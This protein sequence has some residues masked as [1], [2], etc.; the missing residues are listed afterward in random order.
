MKHRIRAAGIALQDNKILMLRVRDQYS[1][2]YWIPPGGGLEDSDVS[3]KQA[4]VRECREE[5]G[6]DVTVGPLLCVREFHEISTDRYHVELFYLLESW[7]GTLSLDNL[8]GLNDS[9]Y[10]QQVAWV[11]I[12]ALNQYK[13]FPADI[14][15]TIL[16]L[17]KTEQFATHLGSY[18]QGSNDDVNYLD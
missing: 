14:A 2:E 11:D 15:S 12:E 1:G 9:E 8:A 6:L 7:S 4:L 5:T 10:I 3:S 13:V 18:V 16:P 17:I